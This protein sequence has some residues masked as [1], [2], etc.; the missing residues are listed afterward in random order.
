MRR[1]LTYCCYFQS[2]VAVTNSE[3]VRDQ[4]DTSRAESTAENL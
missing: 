4:A 2:A 3:T 1:A